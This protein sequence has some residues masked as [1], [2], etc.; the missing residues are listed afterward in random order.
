[1]ESTSETSRPAFSGLETRKGSVPPRIFFPPRFRDDEN[2]R[3][4]YPN[5]SPSDSN[6]KSYDYR[7]VFSEPRNPGF[8]GGVRVYQPVSSRS[9]DLFGYPSSYRPA[10]SE[11]RPHQ[12]LMGFV[13]PSQT[14]FQSEAE[15]TQEAAVI[16][17][18]CSDVTVC[19]LVFS[20]LLCFLG[21]LASI[22]IAVYSG[23]ISDPRLG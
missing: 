1:M 6:C 21:M 8:D 15:I 13:G 9:A 22:H 7:P 20:V 17:R 3:E 23:Y 5:Q 10:F 2:T 18:R 19:C 16:S 11:F 12:P 4:L 14:G